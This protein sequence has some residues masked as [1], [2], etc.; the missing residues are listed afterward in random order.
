LTAA[1]LTAT[2]P[3]TGL[4][5][6]VVV[7]VVVAH[8][9]RNIGR[10]IVAGAAAGCAATAAVLVRA[11]GGG[12]IGVAVMVTYL[13]LAFCFWTF[14]NLNVTSLRIRILRELLAAG[15]S[16]SLGELAARYSDDEFLGRR[17][18]RLEAAKQLRFSQGRWY[19]QS[20]PLLVLARTMD[21]AR[22]VILPSQREE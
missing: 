9:S 3:L 13:A 16:I 1:W 2:A 6:D 11:D 18:V 19:L 17:L 4:I 8:A 22:F 20:R 15:G 5:V 12:A 21:A 14:L 7:Q 10:S